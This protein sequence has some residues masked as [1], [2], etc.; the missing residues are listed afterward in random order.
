[1]CVCEKKIH[2]FDLV[3]PKRKF[4]YILVNRLMANFEFWGYQIKIVDFLLTNQRLQKSTLLVKIL[5]DD[6]EIQNLPI[7]HLPI[8]KKIFILGSVSQIFTN[9]VDF[10][11]KINLKYF[12]TSN[13]DWWK[14]LSQRV[15]ATLYSNNGS[16]CSTK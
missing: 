13:R 5:S 4:S 8:Y 11:T 7:I 9:K 2:N 14:C 12:T 16:L 10:S 3:T 6:Y 1:M 15:K